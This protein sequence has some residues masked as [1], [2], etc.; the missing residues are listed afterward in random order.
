MAE[1]VPLVAAE[2]LFPNA[3]KDGSVKEYVVEH[4]NGYPLCWGMAER[5]AHPL[6]SSGCGLGFP[7]SV[8]VG[9]RRENGL[10]AL[11]REVYKA[12]DS[13]IIPFK[14]ALNNS[15]QDSDDFVTALHS[16]L[17]QGIRPAVYE[18]NLLEV[19]ESFAIDAD[20]SNIG[21]VLKPIF[22]EALVSLRRR[23]PLTPSVLQ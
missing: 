13:S 17:P 4:L 16:D 7:D 10:L 1:P 2:T 12:L 21:F 11:R 18:R 14:T 23:F 8:A 19:N 22:H 6:C 5:V 15:S 9:V 20:G 3:F